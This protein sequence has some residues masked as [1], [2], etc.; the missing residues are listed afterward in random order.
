MFCKKGAF[1][2][3]GRLT[4][5]HLCQSLFFNKVAGLNLFYRTPLDD[6]LLFRKDTLAWVFSVNFAK[7][8]GTPFLTEHLWWLY[9]LRIQWRSGKIMNNTGSL[10]FSCYQIGHLEIVLLLTGHLKKKLTLRARL[11]LSTRSLLSWY[12]IIGV[13]TLWILRDWENKILQ[14]YFYKRWD[15]VVI[16]LLLTVHKIFAW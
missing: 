4:E 1:R 10:T 7:F 14:H 12:I 3:F 6:C 2:N 13:C 15:L 16:C 8:L 9:T 11:I 5:K